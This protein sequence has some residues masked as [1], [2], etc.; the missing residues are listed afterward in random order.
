MTSKIAT[1]A[2]LMR[3]TWPSKVQVVR[4]VEASEVRQFVLEV[5]ACQGYNL[6]ICAVEIYV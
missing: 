5:A 2:P 6:P 4:P 3:H 1:Q